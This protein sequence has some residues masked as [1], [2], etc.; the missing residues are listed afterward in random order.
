MKKKSKSLVIAIMRLCGIIALL[1]AVVIGGTAILSIRTLSKS[2]YV[3]Y[4]T[5]VDEGYQT[6][7]KSQVQSTMAILQSEYDKFQAGRRQRKRQSMMPAKL[8][9]VC[10][11]EMTRAVTS[12]SMTRNIH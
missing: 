3:A 7:I 10:V 9:A 2:A 12:G 8:S 4:E 6:E 5:T 1:T 11:I